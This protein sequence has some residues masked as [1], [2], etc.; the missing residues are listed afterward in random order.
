RTS[1]A[2]DRLG[3]QAPPHERN[4]LTI[5][6]DLVPLVRGFLALVGDLV[7]LVGNPVA[8]VGPIVAR[9][10][11]PLALVGDPLTLVGNLVAFVGCCCAFH[12]RRSLRTRGSAG[13]RGSQPTPGRPR[14]LTRRPLPGC[15]RLSAL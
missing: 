12:A 13:V 9:V 14:S 6:C 5:V 11:D 15:V 1:R 7:A 4:A 3:N 10:R 8:P 2:P